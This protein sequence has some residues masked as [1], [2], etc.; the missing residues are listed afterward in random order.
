MKRHH[1]KQIR[2]EL[3]K[4]ILSLS[5]LLGVVPT[6]YGS[7]RNACLRMLAQ[8]S[9]GHAQLPEEARQFLNLL[10]IGL[11]NLT[12]H[13]P[14]LVQNTEILVDS[15]YPVNPFLGLD[16]PLA[17]ALSSKVETL[18]SKLDDSWLAIR[19]HIE[20]QSKAARN[21]GR[22]KKQNRTSTRMVVDFV[23]VP[24]ETETWRTVDPHLLAYVG[25]TANSYFF[26]DRRTN[27]NDSRIYRLSKIDNSFVTIAQ[28]RNDWRRQNYNFHWMHKDIIYG[29]GILPGEKYQRGR[30][31]RLD[32]STNR[33]TWAEPWHD[34]THVFHRVNVSNTVVGFRGK[35][36]DG[37]INRRIE[38]FNFDYDLFKFVPTGMSF[39]VSQA[40]VQYARDTF[41]LDHIK[42]GEND[43]PI[44]I[45]SLLM[46]DGKVLAIPDSLE[47]EK[48]QPSDVVRAD[49]CWRDQPQGG[50]IVI[51]PIAADYSPDG[52]REWRFYSSEEIRLQDP[53]N[54]QLGNHSFELFS[55]SDM[56][57]S[58]LCLFKKMNF[59]DSYTQ[60]FAIDRKTWKQLP[61]VL[62]GGP[63]LNSIGEWKL[64][65]NQQDELLLQFLSQE[66]HE[67][68]LWKFD[69]GK[70]H[71]D[72]MAH[73]IIPSKY[74]VRAFRFDYETQKPVAWIVSDGLLVFR[75]LDVSAGEGSP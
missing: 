38:I 67:V 70:L 36:V 60:L 26:N 75:D 16:A 74:K 51:Q 59:T 47:W 69:P 23:H 21:K 35:T 64:I 54:F 9:S 63:K 43:P 24:V 71:L 53:D 61:V 19:A 14:K 4:L 56:I 66:L 33:V 62:Q 6:A 65:R 20:A 2:A 45:G 58:I 18:L 8:S 1:P 34:E 7:N 42:G 50:E 5:V 31:F 44:R 68:A 37:K 40:G 15:P 3:Y 17:W 52:L 25:Q 39:D 48:W 46:T 49:R 28:I 10:M 72:L 12:A 22:I 30:L 29:I 27:R 41:S 55:R 32:P 11:E 73:E 13:S 57:N